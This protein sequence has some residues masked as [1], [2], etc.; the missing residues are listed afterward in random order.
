MLE[1][2]HLRHLLWRL[3]PGPARRSASEQN[4]YSEAARLEEKTQSHYRSVTD[5]DAQGRSTKRHDPP[6]P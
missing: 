1:S 5:S 6:S 2:M 3:G 4:R